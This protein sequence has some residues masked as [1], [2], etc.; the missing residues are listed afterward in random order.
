MQCSAGIHRC[1][2]LDF[3][4]LSL[5]PEV[6]DHVMDDIR[7][8]D[9]PGFLAGENAVRRLQKYSSSKKSQWLLEHYEVSQTFEFQGAVL[10]YYTRK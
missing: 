1:Y 8:K 2:T 3:A 10:E 9:L 4:D 6:G 5:R 7:E